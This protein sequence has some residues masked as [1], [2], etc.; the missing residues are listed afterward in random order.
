[1][2]ASTFIWLRPQIRNRSH[3]KLMP[4]FG[5]RWVKVR[6]FVWT[7]N[8]TTECSTWSKFSYRNRS[9]Y[10]CSSESSVDITQQHQK[11]IEVLEKWG[12]STNNRSDWVWLCVYLGFR[13]HISN[14]ARYI[15][16]SQARVLYLN[17]IK[18]KSRWWWWRDFRRHRGK[19]DRKRWWCW[20]WWLPHWAWGVCVCACVCVYA[21]RRGAFV[22]TNIL[23]L[24]VIKVRCLLWIWQQNFLFS[25]LCSTFMYLWRGRTQR[26]K[27]TWTTSILKN[28]KRNMWNSSRAT[29]CTTLTV[30]K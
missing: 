28:T 27:T 21:N 3:W 17:T 4:V 30:Q 13:T 11:N 29:R 14:E 5:S 2:S 26:S 15:K 12:Q 23:S 6:L 20:R 25:A 8:H 16:C 19:K 18:I 24:I 22:I 1:M 10:I 7:T 9:I